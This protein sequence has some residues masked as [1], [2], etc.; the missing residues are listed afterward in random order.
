MVSGDFIELRDIQASG[1]MFYA[2]N[3]STDISNNSG[4]IFN[5]APGYIYGFAGDTTVCTAD[6]SMIGT[7]NFNPD[8]NSTFLW[9]DGSTGSE[10]LV[11]PD[12]TIAYVT[13]TYAEEC[14]YTDTIGIN[15]LPSPFVDVG[16]NTELCEMD[17]LFP[18]QHSDNVSYLW[19]DGSTNPWIVTSTAGI[20]GLTVTNE[21]GCTAYDDLLVDVIPAPI[22]N[23][24]NDTIIHADEQIV[25]DAQNPGASYFWSTGDT[26]QTII[27]GS[28]QT[29]RVEAN[30]DGCS[31]FD[32]IFIDEYPPCT[33]AVPTAFS[34]NADGQNDIL[35]VRGANYLEFELM[36]FSR[37]GEMVFRTNNNSIGW[38]GTYQG[39]PQAVDA[40]N[41]ILT[42]RC[43]DGQIITSKGTITLLR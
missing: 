25:L 30:K 40:Y 37:W 19:H 38:D 27:A 34:P 28:G 23:L 13:V 42:G 22:V 12:D 29:Y 10:Y 3:F 43:I 7:Q 14:S 18:Y 21:Y 36:V 20:Y 24:G 32:T 17:T 9:H 4:W 5:N 6:I 15:H 31:A 11:K 39:Q 2:G 33:L 16:D 26:T 35:Y 1:G 8:E 41:Y